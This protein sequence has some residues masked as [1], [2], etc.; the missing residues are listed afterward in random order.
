MNKN[1]RPI[2][3]IIDLSHSLVPFKY[4]TQLFTCNGYYC[5]SLRK[6][7]RGGVSRDK[8]APPY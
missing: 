3:K 6:N 7:R 5:D 2:I 1:V 8:D 4:F